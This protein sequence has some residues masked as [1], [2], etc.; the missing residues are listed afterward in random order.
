MIRL[1]YHHFANWNIIIDLF[2]DSQCMLTFQKD[3][4]HTNC[5]FPDFKNLQVKLMEENDT[6]CDIALNSHQHQTS[7]CDPIANLEKIQRVESS[8]TEGGVIWKLCKRIQWQYPHLG[9]LY[10]TDILFYSTKIFEEKTER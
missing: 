10:G 7:G 8:D 6:I 9:K 5:I 4:L 1:E 3:Y 2:S